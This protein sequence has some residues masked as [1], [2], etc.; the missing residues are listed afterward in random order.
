MRCDVV[1]ALVLSAIGGALAPVGLLLCCGALVAV[2][3]HHAPRVA[4]AGV[5]AAFFA[6]SRSGDLLA[7]GVL[8]HR[9]LQ[10]LVVDHQRALEADAALAAHGAEVAGPSTPATF[11]ARG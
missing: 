1:I 2:A 9:R 5:V 8:L 7:A 3:R 10:R 4:V 11:G 6:L